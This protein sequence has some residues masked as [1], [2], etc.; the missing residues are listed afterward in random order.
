MRKDIAC[1][2]SLAACKLERW[3]RASFKARVEDHRSSRLGGSEIPLLAYVMVVL[4]TRT[5]D[6]TDI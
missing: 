6:S 3:S 5:R 1:D 2:R 4:Y